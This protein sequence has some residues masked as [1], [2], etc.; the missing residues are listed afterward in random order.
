MRHLQPLSIQPG[1]RPVSSVFRPFTIVDPEAESWG[2][3]LSKEAMDQI[4]GALAKGSARVRV[5][6]QSRIYPSVEPTLVA[7]IRGA[8]SPDE[9]FVF[10]AHVQESGANDN[11]TGMAAAIEAARILTKRSFPTT[12][13]YAGLSAEEQGLHGGRKMAEVAIEE[14]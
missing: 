10:S 12:L 4:R 11:A 1:D 9:R 5:E 2:L 6:V 7:E 13:V 14:G 3:A 8:V